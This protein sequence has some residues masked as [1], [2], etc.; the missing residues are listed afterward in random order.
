MTPS[1]QDIQKRHRGNW[2]NG[3]RGNQAHLPDSRPKF[4]DGCIVS[5]HLS[6]PTLPRSVIP[7]LTYM[8]HHLNGIPVVPV[9]STRLL[10]GSPVPYVVALHNECPKPIACRSCCNHLRDCR[11][12]EVHFST[13]VTISQG[14]LIVDQQ[15]AVCRFCRHCLPSNLSPAPKMSDK[16]R[17]CLCFRTLLRISRSSTPYPSPIN[18]AIN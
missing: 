14:N 4:F 15:P 16:N 9:Q 10:L 7:A 11:A 18:L 2:S 5:S 12:P 8:L 6:G 13:P 1:P 17:T 3:E